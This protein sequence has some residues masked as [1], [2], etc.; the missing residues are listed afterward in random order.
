MQTDRTASAIVETILTL[1]HK[2]NLQ[3]TAEGIE[4]LRQAERLWELGCPYGQGYHFSQPLD[5]EGALN[6]LR[7][8]AVSTHASVAGK[9]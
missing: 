4:T 3:V 8:Q 6:F 5:A 2:M 7:Q 9:S 1:A